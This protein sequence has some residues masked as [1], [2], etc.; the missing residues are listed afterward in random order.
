MTER[1]T[2]QRHYRPSAL[3]VER[4]FPG[5][6]VVRKG[7]FWHASYGIHEATGEDTAELRESIISCKHRNGI[8]DI[9]AH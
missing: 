8:W 2:D 3:E 7:K 5:W 6:S 4:E 1:V 9:A